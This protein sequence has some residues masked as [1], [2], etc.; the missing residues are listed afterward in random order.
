MEEILADYEDL[1]DIQPE[2]FFWQTNHIAEIGCIPWNVFARVIV[3]VL[4]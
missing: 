4:G 3:K 1:L 2:R